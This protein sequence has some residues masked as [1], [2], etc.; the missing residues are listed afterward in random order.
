MEG[1]KIQPGKD[2]RC[3]TKIY[4]TKTQRKELK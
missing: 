3:E 2:A 4:Q 1:L